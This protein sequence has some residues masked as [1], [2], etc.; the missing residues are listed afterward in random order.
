[1]NGMCTQ[2]RSRWQDGNARYGGSSRNKDCPL[3]L[4]S[5]DDRLNRCAGPP[6]RLASKYL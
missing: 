3:G 2:V 6:D 1:M 5:T 4:H